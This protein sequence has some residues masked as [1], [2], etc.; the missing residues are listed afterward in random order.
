MQSLDDLREKI[1]TLENE[2]S[3]LR[4]EVETLR[5]AAEAR[6]TLLESEVSQLRQEVRS[7]REFL[8]GSVEPVS[9]LNPSKP[10]TLQ[11]G[12]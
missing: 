8:G 9:G 2:K 10:Q 11:K 5:K 7:L 4:V 6:A 12:A 1:R 3:R